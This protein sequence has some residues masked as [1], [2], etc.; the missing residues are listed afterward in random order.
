MRD[1]TYVQCAH[2]LLRDPREVG[3][4]APPKH[5]AAYL[6]QQSPERIFFASSKFGLRMVTF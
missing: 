5:A 3:S 2:H 6:A 1:I 4:P